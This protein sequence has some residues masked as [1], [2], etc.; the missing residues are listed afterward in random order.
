MKYDVICIGAG[1][2]GTSHAYHAALKGKKVLLIEKDFKPYEG[3]VRNFGQVVPSGQELSTWRPYGIS[4]LSIYKSIQEEFDISARHNG[5]NY[6]AGDDQEMQLLEEMHEIDKSMDYPSV[7]MTQGELLEKFPSLKKDYVKGGLFYPDE[8]SAEPHQL[9]HRFIEYIQQKFNVDFLNNTTITHCEISGGNALVVTASGQKFTADKVILCNGRDFKILF[10]DLFQ[11]SGMQVSKLQMMLTSKMPEVQLPGNILTG[12]T[13]RRY[14]GFHSCPSYTKFNETPKDAEFHR[15]GI[16][17]LFKQ[18]K[19]GSIIIGDSHEYA[20][21]TNTEATDFINHT[22][23]NN[24][25]LEEAK[26]IMNFPEWN[27]EQTWNGF[28]ATHPEEIY[29]HQIDNIIHIVTGIGGKGMT[30]SLG[31]SKQNIDKILA[32]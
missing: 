11:K 3:S 31:F 29:S 27:I 15:L 7:L 1:I 20:P 26:K 23:I 9:I 6:I 32:E 5:S 28:Y 18:A 25:M 22:Y 17:V 30:C 4:S 12:Y 10:P 8:I 24:L 19:D 13:I 21:A 14:E 2:L 16:H